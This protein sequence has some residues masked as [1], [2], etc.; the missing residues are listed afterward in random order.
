MFA[1]L[2][3]KKSFLDFYGTFM[4]NIWDFCINGFNILYTK[5]NSIYHLH[6]NTH[7]NA[8]EKKEKVPPPHPYLGLVTYYSV[9][10]NTDNVVWVFLSM[11]VLSPFTHTHN[12]FFLV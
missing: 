7:L 12:Q 10:Q 8:K 2:K 11:W 3:I 1:D 9:H 4:F 5:K 6:H